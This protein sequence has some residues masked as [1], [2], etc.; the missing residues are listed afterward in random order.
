MPELKAER[1]ALWNEL[2]DMTIGGEDAN[3]TRCMLEIRAGTGGEEAALFARDLYEMYKH[4]AEDNRWKVE[5]LD[6]IP[7]SWAGSRKSSWASKAKA[8]SASCN[9][10]AAAI[11][12]SACPKPR[13]R[14]A[15]TPRPPPWP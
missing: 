12:S 8:S 9:T 6:M 15:S 13:P 10:R 11:A 4:Y 7:P 3:R 14:A 1:E 2:L 5:I